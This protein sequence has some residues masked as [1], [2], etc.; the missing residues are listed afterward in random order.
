MRMMVAV[1]LQVVAVFQAV[2][3]Q[4]VAILQIAEG[5]KDIVVAI[6]VLHPCLVSRFVK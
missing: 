3:V 1:V 5:A 4:T 6:K 2:A